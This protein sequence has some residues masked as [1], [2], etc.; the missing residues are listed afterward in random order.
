M[1][2]AY[3]SRVAPAVDHRRLLPRAIGSFLSQFHSDR[4]LSMV[5]GGTEEVRDH[6]RSG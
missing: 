5:D 6:G 4:E 2:M 3:V 1:K